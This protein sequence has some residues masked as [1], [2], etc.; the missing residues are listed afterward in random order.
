M[1]ESKAKEGVEAGKGLELEM[2]LKTLF[3]SVASEHFLK[4]KQIPVRKKKI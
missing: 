4:F 1:T 3:T 2:G